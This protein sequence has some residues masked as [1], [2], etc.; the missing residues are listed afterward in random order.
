MLYAL[1]A[2]QD[3]EGSPDVVTGTLRVFDLDSYPLLDLGATL[4]FMN[5]Y[6]AVRFIVSPKIF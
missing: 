6:I 4:S 1:Q 2:R 3:L 5:P